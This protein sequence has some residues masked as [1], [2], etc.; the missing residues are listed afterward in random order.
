M[1]YLVT[2]GE[3]KEY[4][5]NTIVHMGIPSLVLMERAALAVRDEIFRIWEQQNCGKNVLVVTGSGNNGADGLALA[6]LLA[7]S[8]FE[9]TVYEWGSPDYRTQEY[10]K[11]KE[12]LGFYE[13][14]YAEDL[15]DLKQKYD[16]VVD[17]IFG[18]GLSRPVNENCAQIIKR[19]NALQGN[20]I[21]IDIPSGIHADS[22]RIMGEAFLADVTVTFGFGK[23]GL[24]LFPG[25]DYAGRIVTAPIGITE[26]SFLRKTP[27]MFIFEE[28]LKG[29]LPKRRR[30]G[31][32]G[33]FGKVLLIAGWEYMAGAGILAAQALLRT[34]AGMVKVF[35]SE[36]NREILQGAVPEA[37]YGNKESLQKDLKWADVIVAGPGLGQ[38]EKACQILR[39]VLEEIKETRKSLL[40]DADALNLLGEKE[41]LK[42]I[43]QGAFNPSVIMTPHMGELARLSGYTIDFVK[44]HITE[45]AKEEA[46]AYDSVMVCKDA[47]TLVFMSNHPMYLNVNGNSGMATAGSGDVLSGIIGAL[48]AQGQSPFSAACVGV[49]LHGMAGD[50]AA[51]RYSEYGVTASGITAQIEEIMKGSIAHGCP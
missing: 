7:E 21:A 35:C 28:S 3:M 29:L 17:G 22:G 48:L 43:L 19:M 11:Q 51:G 10:R 33:T 42:K 36:Q 5:K 27:E 44:T 25:A 1:K 24:Y 30:D 18:V 12:I 39:Q 8:G 50:R 23:R 34:G 14:I 26:R 6:R 9:V 38:S 40:L 45:V 31:N 16:F 41:A 15:S 2:S 37:M 49:Y 20:K 32:K 46:L 47:R 4:D 13:I